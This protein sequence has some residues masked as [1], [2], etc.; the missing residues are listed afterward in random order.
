MFVSEM[1]TFGEFVNAFYVWSFWL[2]LLKLLS[3]IPVH[4]RRHKHRHF[5]NMRWRKWRRWWWMRHALRNRD[6]MGLH[7]F[8]QWSCRR[9]NWDLR[10]R[11]DCRSNSRKVRRQQHCQWRWLWLQLIC[12]GWLAV[13]WRIHDSTR[14]LHRHLR[15]RNC[16]GLIRRLLWWW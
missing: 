7:H 8:C 9:L 1:P 6:W 4:L 16:R 5:R 2:S 13:I 15:R 12:R 14:C 10:R 11:T 3:R